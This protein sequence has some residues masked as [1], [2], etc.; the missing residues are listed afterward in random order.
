MGFGASPFGG[1]SNGI[2]I[3]D[4]LRVSMFTVGT[5]HVTLT[6]DRDVEPLMGSAAD[7]TKYSLSSTGKISTVTGVS[8]SGRALTVRFTPQTDSIVYTLSIPDTGI[9]DA[10]LN[11]YLGPYTFAYNSQG[12]PINIQIVSVIDARTLEVVFSAPPPRA[13]ALN[14][15]T[16]SISPT[17]AVLGVQYV[18]DFVYQLTT[19]KQ[20]A[21][22]NYTI[23]VPSMFL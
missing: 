5:D 18:T 23:T 17:I 7:P 20:T 15:A 19:E 12:T 2:S 1:V 8:L 22:T 9:L 4:R 3:G 13:T 6:F 16:Y 11:P 10:G 14:P 21:G